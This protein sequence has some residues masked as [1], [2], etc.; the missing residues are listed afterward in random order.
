MTIETNRKSKLIDRP[1]PVDRPNAPAAQR[2]AL[3]RL[4]WA[5]GRAAARCRRSQIK[6]GA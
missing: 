6:K 1:R 2:L 5:I 4:L 3:Y